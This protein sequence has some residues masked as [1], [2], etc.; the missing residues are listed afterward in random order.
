MGH[1]VRLID[2]LAGRSSG[3]YMPDNP[4][5][6]KRANPYRNIGSRMVAD[7]IGNAFESRYIPQQVPLV[8]SQ[9]TDSSIYPHVDVSANPMYRPMQISDDRN[10][11]TGL[12]QEIQLIPNS[13][14]TC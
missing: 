2:Y 8:A 3:Q 4:F 12:F 14:P 1:I 10:Y 5:W 9:Y 11:G 13:V 7:S 6:H